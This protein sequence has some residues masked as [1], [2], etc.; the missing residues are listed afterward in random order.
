MAIARAE[1]GRHLV[2]DA[3]AFGD[4][5]RAGVLAHHGRRPGDVARGAADSVY[6][7]AADRG[8]REHR[9]GRD[10]RAIT[11][12]PVGERDE[13]HVQLVDRHDL[14]AAAGAG[15]RESDSR[16]PSRGARHRDRAAHALPL[17]DPLLQSRRRRSGQ[18]VRHRAL[19]D[20]A[21]HLA[22]ARR[23]ARGRDGQRR[24]RDRGHRR[25]GAARRAT[26]HVPGSGVGDPGVDDGRG[27][28]THAARLPPVSHRDDDRGAFG[29]RRGEHRREPRVARRRP[30]DGAFGHRGPHARDRRRRTP[31]GADQH[32]APDRRQHARDRRQRGADR[33][34][35]AQDAAGR[36][37]SSSPSTTRR[38]SSA[39]R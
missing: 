1:R 36:G 31:G 14:R 30:G 24:P 19:P 39:K 23:G 38:R 9:A 29:G 18:A 22:R 11:I 32:H 2:R 35:A 10:A 4:L 7:H 33:D 20:K 3:P 34:V 27:G 12:D 17:P 26:A 21:A 16:R 28:R 13:H 15:A 8:G 6:R 37:R 25:P 5:S